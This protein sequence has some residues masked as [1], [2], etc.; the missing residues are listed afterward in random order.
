MKLSRIIAAIALS[1]CFIAVAKDVLANSTVQE[2]VA[3]ANKG[4]ALITG[5]GPALPD[6]YVVRL[7]KWEDGHGELMGTDTIANGQFRFEMPL[8]EDMAV[9]SLIFDYYAFPGMN[10]KLYLTPGATVDIEAVDNFSYTWPVKS[11]VPEQAEYELFINNSYDLWTERQ[12][13]EKEYDKTENKD[14]LQAIDSITRLVE[15][16][17]LELLKTRPVGRVWLEKAKDLAVMSDRLKIDTEDLKSLYA[18]LAD[19]IKNSPVGREIYGHLYAGSPI[20]IGDKFP[21]TEFYDLDGNVHKFTEFQGKWCLVDIWNSGCSPC[22]RAMPELK[23]LKEKYPEK[24]EVVSL[25]V[26]SENSWRQASERLHLSGNNWNE[27]KLNYGIFKRLGTHAYPTFFVVSPDGTIKDIWI[28][29]ASGELIQKVNFNLRPKG[30]TEYTE[31]KGHRTIRFPR[32]QANKT[33]RVLDIDRIEI[34]DEGTKVFFAFVYSPDKWI[35]ISTDAYIKDSTGKQYKVIRT[36]GIT[37]GE[38]LYP[39]KEGNGSFSIIFEPIPDYINSIDFHESASNDG[40]SIEGIAL[41]P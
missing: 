40:W 27:G 26:D 3:D 19:S 29:Y 10:H 17:N 32:Y 38:H 1:M 23:A 24:L 39:D 18:N 37:L 36:D 20:V 14:V 5:H 33:N 6:E 34:S 30:E 13:A 12:K 11:N 8:K 41:N 22:I 2:K 31:S 4:S 28:G 16:R 21:D 35:A 7:Y 25:S 9:C 15:L